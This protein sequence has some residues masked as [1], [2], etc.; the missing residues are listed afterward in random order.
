MIFGQQYQKALRIKML[1]PFQIQ[2]VKTLAKQNW[3]KLLKQV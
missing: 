2:L 1:K 3:N